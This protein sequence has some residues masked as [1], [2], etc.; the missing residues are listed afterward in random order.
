MNQQNTLS[1]ETES[2]SKIFQEYFENILNNIFSLN[3]SAGNIR[4]LLLQFCFF[5]VWLIFSL[6]LNS[7]EA[8][9]IRL[10]PTRGFFTSPFMDVFNQLLGLMFSWNVIILMSAIVSGFYIAFQVASNYLEDIFELKD[11]VIAQKY[12]KLAAFSSSAIKSIHIENGSVRFEDQNSPIFRIGGPGNVQINLEN[13]VV[14]EKIDGAPNI[15]GPTIIEDIR[16]EGFERI[17]QIIDLRDQTTSFDIFS[18]TREGIPL[19]IKDIRLL[20]SVFRESHNISLANPYPFYKAS[21]HWLVYQQSPGNWTT[22]LVNLV[23]EELTKFIS[24]HSIGEILAAIGEPEITHQINVQE[25]LRL[26]SRIN[27]AHSRR[28]KILRFF[29][30]SRK[31]N[32]PEYLPV[33][34]RNKIH[35]KQPRSFKNK[36]NGSNI[37]SNFLPRTH[38]SN[39][40]YKEFSQTFYQQARKHGVRLEWINVGTW[41]TPAKLIPEQHLAA[42]KISSQNA[43]NS[44]PKVLETQ[45]NQVRLN[46]LADNIQQLPIQSFI[47]LRESAL[48]DT[49]IRN[50]LISEY[51]SKFKLAREIFIKRIGRVPIQVENALHHLRKYQINILKENSF[52]IGEDNNENSTTAWKE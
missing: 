3:T 45:Y 50:A 10:F 16:L 28:Y 20:F 36:L 1:T 12:L 51:F 32:G 19:A 33:Y 15:A 8:A 14:F 21:L 37:N 47:T 17:R 46:T 40:F 44:N 31:T 11:P 52:F 13:A 4:S 30:K 2:T 39:L 43:I 9:T 22:S 29:Y 27:R 41:H 25:N 24:H 48:P 38:L 49:K 34:F 5:T 18:R 42:W 35:S 26:R 6:T 23:R 7:Q